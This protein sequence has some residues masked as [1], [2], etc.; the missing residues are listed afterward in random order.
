MKSTVETLSP[1]RVRLSVE[2]PFEELA[3]Y[4]NEAYKSVGQQIRVPGFRPGKAPRPVIDQRVG[5]ESVYAQ[6][7]D[8][9]VQANLNKAVTDNDVNALGRPELTD[10][11]P[12]EEGK[13]FEFVVETDVTPE[14]ELPDFATLKVTVEA[15]DVSEEDIDADLESQRL[16]FSSLKT[17]ER[18]AAEGDFVVI[19]LKATQNG[20]EVEGGSVTGM[21]HEVGSGNLLDGLDEALVGMS[22]EDEKTIQSTLSGEQE[23]ETA[24]V[25]VRVQQVK[26]RELPELD[27][28][29]A[30]MSSPY[31]TLEE[32]RD[33]T[34][35]RLEQQAVAG[36]ATEARS[37][38]LDALIEAVDLPLPEKTVE[39]E[40]EHTRGHL[41]EQVVQMAGSFEE[42]LAAIEKTAEEFEADLRGDVESNL[43][44][45]IILGRIA[46]E[47]EVEVS[48]EL[49][50]SEVVRQAQQRGVP[51]EQF[52]Q[53][54]DQLR[55]N[56]GLQQI[57]SQLRQQLALEEVVKAATIVDGKG[58]E[59]T[60]DDLFPG[61]AEA[62]AAE[63]ESTEE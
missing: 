13:P 14:Y 35:E 49:M 3:P 37:K 20:E 12:I 10:V 25:E 1:T 51:Q 23:G 45:S 19:D 32:L 30:E 50:T 42:Y 60:E 4:I 56:G 40:I 46:R 11:K 59:L 55:E 54:V 44:Q 16:R 7:M 6:A 36:K 27:D 34:R 9:A 48:G 28:E 22:A 52:Q 17:V 29:F 38:T 31:D 33:A 18:A 62:E 43:R 26:E 58:N 41:E 5:R 24:D 15:D 63:E 53:F 47:K 21:S 61:R 2:V 8:P 57:A 39:E